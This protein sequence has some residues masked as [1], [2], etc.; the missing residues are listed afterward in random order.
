M[1]FGS[2]VKQELKGELF[3]NI[4][5]KVEVKCLTFGEFFDY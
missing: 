3:N 4:G 1:Y 2:N 5:P